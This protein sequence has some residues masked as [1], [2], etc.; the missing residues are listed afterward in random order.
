MIR[1]LSFLITLPISL[2]VILFAVSNT[3][4]APVY[5]NILDASFS[6]PQYGISLGLMALGFLVGSLLVW[7]NLYHFRIR[8]WQAQRK[9]QRF[10]DKNDTIRDNQLDQSKA[11]LD[12]TPTS[13]DASEDTDT[14]KLIG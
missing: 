6:L 5:F 4:N 10:E 7:L 1:L 9:L 2:F 13:V 11:L 3:Q 8:F 14:R 12:T